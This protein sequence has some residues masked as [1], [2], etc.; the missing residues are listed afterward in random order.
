MS[1]SLGRVAF[2]A[3]YAAPTGIRT[4]PSEEDIDVTWEAFGPE[5]HDL[6]ETVARAVVAEHDRRTHGEPGW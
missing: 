6:W 4:R 2:G 3:S 1:R 5:F